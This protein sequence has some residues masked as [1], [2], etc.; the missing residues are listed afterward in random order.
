MIWYKNVIAQNGEKCEEV[1]TKYESLTSKPQRDMGVMKKELDKQKNSNLNLI[2]EINQSLQD[3]NDTDQAHFFFINGYVSKIFNQDTIYY[4]ACKE[5]NRK[6]IEDSGGFRCENCGKN[7]ADYTPTYM[8][9]AQISDFTDS[10]RVT[11]PR[12][13]G[14]TLMGGMSAFDFRK[15]KD[16]KSEDEVQKYLDDLLFKSFNVMVKAKFDHYNGETRMKYYAVRVFPHNIQNENKALLSRLEL[17]QNKK[18]GQNITI[19]GDGFMM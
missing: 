16:E 4:Q 7:F 13:Q 15:F 8:F 6:V 18:E 5:C 11:F 19:G 12:E 17:Y 9:T 2:C 14:N 1:F 3:A 10:I